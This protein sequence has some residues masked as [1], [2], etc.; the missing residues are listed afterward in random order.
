MFKLASDGIVIFGLKIYFYALVIITGALLG[1]F[2]AS[3]EAK[4]RGHNPEIIWDVLPWILIAGII[5]ARL[6]H[7]FTP[8]SSI[9]I[10]GVNPYFIHPLEAFNFRQGGLGIPGGVIAGVLAL[11]IYARKK[12]LVFTSWLD[13]LAPGLALAQGIGRWG[14][15]FNQELYGLKTSVTWFPYAVKI[16]NEY[17]LATFFY[18]FVWNLVNMLLLLW[19]PRKLG[20]KMKP[21]D[22]FLVYMIFYGIG[23]FLLEFIR[24][25]Y[26]P[27][28][29]INI[30]QTIMG[31]VVVI[32]TAV[33]VLRHVKK[34]EPIAV[35]VVENGQE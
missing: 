33:L 23:R 15:F 11:Y 35:A 18:E 3:K 27:I 28:A 7:V 24:L 14:N 32:S 10:N 2:L 8:S 9:L 17:Y 6:W 4:R 12:K 31:V 25:E 21:G 22:N 30:N 1:A 20:D 13:I 26:S 29:G 16:N 5:G 19:L 34:K